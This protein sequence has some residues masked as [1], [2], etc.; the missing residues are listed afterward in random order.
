MIDLTRT[1][2]TEES[3]HC[4]Y[5]N[6]YIGDI[7]KEDQVFCFQFGY[8]TIECWDS[9]TFRAIADALDKLNNVI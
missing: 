9:A 3:Y 8:D 2:D 4:Y 7:F 6:S 1:T 5:N